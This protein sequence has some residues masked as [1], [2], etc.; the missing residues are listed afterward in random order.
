MPDLMVV[1]DDKTV[2]LTKC[3]WISFL[4]CGCPFG[5]LTAAFGDEAFAT[6]EQA[7]REIYPLKRERDRFHKAGRRLELMP[8]DRYRAEIDL[9]ARCPHTKGATSQATLDA[10]GGE[11]A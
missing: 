3:V 1:I 2:P 11:A 5:V 9:S 10:A 4:A 6:E 8:W 7:L